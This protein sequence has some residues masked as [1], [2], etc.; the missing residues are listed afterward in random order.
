[1]SAPNYA[2]RNA[3]RYFII[4]EP[5]D[6]DYWFWND[7]KEDIANIAVEKHGFQWLEN[8]DWRKKIGRSDRLDSYPADALECYFEVEKKDKFNGVWRATLVPIVRSGYYQH[9]CLD[10]YI[11]LRT[12]YGDDL[13]N[14]DALNKDVIAETI[15]DYYEYLRDYEQEDPTTGDAF[16]LMDL[17]DS[18]LADAIEKFYAWAEDCG[19]DEYTKAWQGSNGEAR[20]T[21]L[22]EIKRKAAA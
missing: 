6:A 17:V 2:L 9:A 15:N 8:E 19:I 16:E 22:S 5:E 1:M 3:K 4:E 7:T 20:Y 11:E 18:V 12:E 14:E 21:N 10:F 13:E